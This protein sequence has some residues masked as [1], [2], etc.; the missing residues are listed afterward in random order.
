MRFRLARIA[1]MFVAFLF[2]AHLAFSALPAHA[3]TFK[4]LR[5]TQSGNGVLTMAPD[6]VKEVT[7]TFQNQGDVTWK[8]DGYGYFSVY[9]YEPKYRKSVFDPATWLG[10]TQVKRIQEASVAPKGTATVA[11]Q[12]HA[13]KTEGTYT[14]T[15]ALASES[16]A[17]V[18]GGSFTFVISV[19]TPEVAAEEEDAS[20]E[21]ASDDGLAAKLAMQSANKAK[22][23]AGK[24]VLLTVGFTNTGTKTWTSV[25]L[26]TPSVGMATTEASTFTHPSWSGQ[27]LAYAEQTVKPGETGYVTFSLTAPKTNGTHT[28]RFQFAANDIAID[29]AFVELPVE[30]TGGAR[31]AVRAEKVIDEDTNL[32]DEPIIRVGVLIIDEETDNETVMTSYESDFELRDI[33]GNLLGEVTKGTEVTARYENGKYVFDRGRGE[34]TSTYALRWVP[35]TANAVMTITNFDRR[36]TRG[37]ANADNTFRGVLELRY[38]DHKERA[39]IINELPME[40][41]LRGLAETS[42]ISHMEYQKALLSAARTYAFYH[43]TRAT[44]HAKEY[45]HVD[46]YA[47][48]VY[49]GYGQEQRTPRLTEA[50]EL[51]RGQVVTYNGETAITAYFSRSDGR[52]RD[53][54][55]VWGGD[56]PWSKG[57]AVPCDEGK[58]LWGHG[59]GMSASGALCMANNGMLWDDILKYFYTGIELDQRWK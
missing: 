36:V 25:G 11:F 59:V 26:R 1:T 4:A 22:L 32:I 5:V 41:Y 35:K 54:S 3:A 45:F 44:K 19:K 28:A 31:E 9:T 58:V 7:V 21:L 14:E 50:L 52:T 33:N 48:Q 40:Y 6:E 38:N 34:E 43:W 29:D 30:V 55:E 23:T 49:K 10:P 53:W 16:T 8:N 15:F 56:V 51:T 12:L 47:D 39:W 20:G 42:N 37:S 57:V 13:P 24:S 2:G 18:E 17:W 46:A 27:Q